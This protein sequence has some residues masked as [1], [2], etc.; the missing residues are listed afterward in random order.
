MNHKKMEKRYK[1]HIIQ[2]LTEV[3]IMVISVSVVILIAMYFGRADTE[4]SKEEAEFSE[5]ASKDRDVLHVWYN[6]KE[7]E[8][9][10]SA[11][12]KEYEKETG[13]DVEIR[14]V[15]DLDYLEEIYKANKEDGSLEYAKPDV[16]LIQTEDLEAVYGYG[17]AGEIENF[18]QHEA[19][20]LKNAVKNVTFRGKTLAY[21]LSFDTAFLL[22]RSDYITNEPA[23]FEEMVQFSEQF[24][25]EGNQNV[26]RVF[27]Y[28]AADTFHNYGFLGAYLQF[29]G[30]TGDDDKSISLCSEAAQNA[31]LYY[32]KLMEKWSIHYG[33]E[34]YN[35]IPQ[36]FSNGEI[37]CTIVTIRELNQIEELTKDKELEYKA[38]VLPDMNAELET[39]SLSFTQGLAIN[40][41]SDK[42][43]EALSFV[44]YATLKRSDLIYEYA[45]LLPAK[46]I[47]YSDEIYNVIQEQYE[48]AANLPKL[49]MAA[50]YYVRIGDVFN[51]ALKGEDVS[52]ALS[53]LEENYKKR[54][55]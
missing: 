9:Y 21:P 14:Y 55:D 34:D 13:T 49:M 53:D 43:E 26:K 37:L 54:Q 23:S 47:S 40:Y 3:I 41:L 15:S 2:A 22:Y 20:F 4:M 44:Q 12:E 33:L 24:D 19:E 42:E 8:A 28:N 32:R 7:Y 48:N 5:S 6:D 35:S 11:L 51:Q 16:F 39:Q 1:K 17:M 18:K 30:T 45:G 50:D 46:Q 27:Y 29:G 38:C 36:K 52:G 31:V 25:Y 10:F